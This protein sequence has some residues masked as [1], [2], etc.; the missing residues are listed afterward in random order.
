M[1]EEDAQYLTAID[2][3]FYFYAN[4]FCF[5]T[6]QHLDVL[7]KR[8]IFFPRLPPPLNDEDDE[9]DRVFV[10]Q[11]VSHSDGFH[12]GAVGCHLF[13]FAPFSAV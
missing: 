12:Y 4:G 5:K 3:F 6:S 2:G 9:S 7:E 11:T 1:R 8:P 10:R 13:R